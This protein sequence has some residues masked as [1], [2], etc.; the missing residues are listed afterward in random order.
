MT[1][2][3][4]L[5][6]A[7]AAAATMALSL[8]ACGG[9]GAK[10][11]ADS[12]GLLPLKV[13]YTAAGAGYADLYTGVEQGIFKRHGLDVTLVR[14]NTSAQL[15]A[16]LASNSVQI[17]VG[18]AADSAKAIIKGAK[19]KFIAMSEP[20][21][22]L[23]MWASPSVATVPD[24]KG[25]KVALTSPGSEGDFGLTALL[26]EHGM[27]RDDVTVDYV[28]S[29][30]AEVAALDSGSVQAIL[31]QPPQ[32]TSTRQ[33]G[34]HRLASLANLP[35][36]L[37]T[38]TVQSGY[39]DKN[40]DLVKKFVAAE[41]DSLKYLPTHPRQTEAAIKKYTGEDDAALDQYAYQFF[42]AVWAKTP[43]VR[44]D[45]IKQG[46]QEA[47]AKTGTTAPGNVAPYI[48]TTLYPPSP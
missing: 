48:D 31:T 18:V 39:L 7:T 35:F 45:L 27:S 29:A 33:K 44:T 5:A 26:T 13:G 6:V 20:S 17:G 15:V 9:A 38:Y 10:V 3:R 8:A 36:P 25:K 12:S 4:T 46:F 32:G 21:Y 43:R 11:T 16:G 30:A 34:A 1:R 14:L 24:L 37:G 42:L 40:R 47:A 23:E 2:F 22:N 19:L 41:A 28:Q